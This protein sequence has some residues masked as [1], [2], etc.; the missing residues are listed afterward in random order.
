MKTRVSK[1]ND[2]YKK[3]IKLVDLKLAKNGYLGKIKVYDKETKTLL[4]TEKY[5]YLQFREKNIEDAFQKCYQNSKKGIFLRRLLH[6]IENKQFDIIQK[7]ESE[8]NKILEK[9]NELNKHAQNEKIILEYK[10][11]I[12]DNE[13]KKYTK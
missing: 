2:D 1:E 5:E 11:K 12:L 10:I 7:L 4:L 9:I 3:I 6:K 13:L 8:K